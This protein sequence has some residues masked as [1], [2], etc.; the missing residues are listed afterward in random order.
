MRLPCEDHAEVTACDLRV[1]VDVQQ[2][3]VNSV[4]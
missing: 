4:R 2:F 3:R 1:A